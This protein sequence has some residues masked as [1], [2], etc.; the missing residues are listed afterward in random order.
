M[1]ASRILCSL[2]VL[3]AFSSNAFAASPLPLP[4]GKCY[5]INGGADYNMIIYFE[6]DYPKQADSDLSDINGMFSSANEGAQQCYQ[7]MKSELK[8]HVIDKITKSD[9]AIFL[10]ASTDT[11]ASHNYNVKLAKRRAG[12]AMKALKDAGI[13]DDILTNQVKLFIGGESNAATESSESGSNPKERA[14]RIIVKQAN[15]Y[16]PPA[17]Y[18]ETPLTI[19]ITNHNTTENTITSITSVNV[20]YAQQ[21]KTEIGLIVSELKRMNGEFDRSHW[22]T[23]SGNFN[24]ARLAS[25]SIAGVVLGTAGGL[26][27]SNVIKKNQIRG[28]FEDLQCVIGG[29][30]VAN[31]NDEF[32]T[33]INLQQ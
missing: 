24:G 31:Y 23:A 27:T 7:N 26:I 25:D 17:P 33:R 19:N 21:K 13:S 32:T 8:K 2:L 4:G 15:D 12:F 9:E 1:K 14:I 3:G 11:L 6:N 28:G 16:S 18:H 20:N 22:K 29:Q 10:L 30:V 5:E